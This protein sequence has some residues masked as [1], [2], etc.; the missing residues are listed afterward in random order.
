[1]LDFWRKMNYH[2]LRPCRPAAVVALTT[3]LCAN[4]KRIGRKSGKFGSEDSSWSSLG[5]YVHGQLG[6]DG[7][8]RGTRCRGLHSLWCSSSEFL[9][10]CGSCRTSW[11]CTG[12][13]TSD[14]VRISMVDACGSLCGLRCVSFHL[15]SS[16]V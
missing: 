9:D 7:R 1:M 6:D 16:C 8:G 14:I 5:L 10:L 11:G 4:A 15:Y 13:V 2:V 3:M 12:G